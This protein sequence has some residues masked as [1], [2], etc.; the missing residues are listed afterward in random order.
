MMSAGLDFANQFDTQ[1]YGGYGALDMFDIGKKDE[2]K[3]Q[4]MAIKGMIAR[5]RRG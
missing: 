3:A 1:S 2:P 4:F 5:Y